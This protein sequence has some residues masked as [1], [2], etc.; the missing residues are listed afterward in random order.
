MPDINRVS[1]PEEFFDITSTKLLAQPEPQFLYAQMFMAACG[2]SLGGLGGS[3]GLAGRE[4]SGVGAAYSSADRDRLVLSN[5]LMNGVFAA[6]V[7]FSGGTGSVVRFNRPSFANT[8]Y[9]RASRRVAANTSISTTTI[10][11]GSEQTNLQLERFAGPY[12]S[13][14]SRV[15]PFGVDKFAAAMSVHNLVNFA[16]THMVRDFH[17]F[18]DTVVVSLLDEAS[19][20]VRPAGMSADNDATVAGSFPMDF[21]TVV[22]AEEAADNANLPVFPDGSR[23]LV[24]TPKQCAQLKTDGDFVELSKNHPEYNA[25]FPQYLASV[26]KLHIFKS[27]TLDTANNSSSIAIHKGHL[28]APGALLGG[29]G[30]PPRVAPSSDDNYGELAKLIWIAYLAFGVADDRFAISVRTS[31]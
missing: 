29:M 8:T 5:P 24:L 11:A 12:D 17:K 1:V 13:T 7:D 30:A 6:S 25:L 28:I 19:T 4:I 26:G 9:T 15:A 21:D 20:V 16:G 3:V 2:V 27:T 31:A 22:R 14:N 23:L 10:N 18:I